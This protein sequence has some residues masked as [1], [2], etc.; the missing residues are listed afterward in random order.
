MATKHDTGIASEI[1]N[2]FGAKP[3][4]LVQVLHAF[5]ERYGYISEE[6]IRQIA[7][8]LNLSRAEVH[9]V[10]SFYHDF[11]TTPARQAHPED[12][13]GR[14]LPGDGQP[15]AHRSGGEETGCD[16][17][18]HDGRRAGVARA[19]LLPRPVCL[20]ACRHGDTRSTAG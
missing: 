20:L 2:R 19:G 8:E 6:A 4:L 1:I 7:E 17:E 5:L 15:R 16:D 18:Q 13:P 10:V 12:L 3:E 14:I 9:G 11:R